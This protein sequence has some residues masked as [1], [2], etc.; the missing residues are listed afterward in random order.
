MIGITPMIGRND[1]SSEV[2][3]AKDAHELLRFA[4]GRG[5]GSL[6]LWSLARDRGCPNGGASR[7]M[8]QDTCSG[9]SQTPFEFTHLFER[10]G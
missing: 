2:F 8:A 4:R 9:V 6:S 1:V 10:F 3:T 7:P 5:I